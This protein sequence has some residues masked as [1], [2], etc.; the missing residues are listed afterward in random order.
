MPDAPAIAQFE[1]RLVELGCPGRRLREKVQELADHYEDLRLAALEDGLPEAEAEARATALLGNPV[2][3]AEDIVTGL[4]HSS[5]WGRHPFIGL[6]LLPPL[7]VGFFWAGCAYALYGIGYLLGWAFGPGYDMKKMAVSLMDADGE[8]FRSF[9]RPVSAGLDVASF[10]ILTAAF[11][12]VARRSAVGLRW[13]LG[14]CIACLAT[15]LAFFSTIEPHNV[16]LSMV[17]PPRHWWNIGI[18]V[19]A[20][21]FAF[22]R[23]RRMESLLTPIPAEL[24]RVRPG[25]SAKSAKTIFRRMC[26]TPTYWVMAVLVVFIAVFSIEYKLSSN[27]E[28]ARKAELKNKTWPAERATTLAR[29]SEGQHATAPNR[30]TTINLKPWL[31]ATLAATT[32]GADEAKDNNLAELPKGIHTFAG[33]P[34]DV[35]GRAQLLGRALLESGKKFPERIRNIAIGRK[36]DRIHL[37]HGASNLHTLHKEIAKLRL[38]YKN[39]AVAEIGI[40]SGEHVLDWWGPI[41]TTDAGNGCHPTA[42]ETELAWVGENPWIKEQQPEDSLRLY[43]STFANPHPDLEIASID[44]VSTLKDAAPF[45]VGLTVDQSTK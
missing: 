4:R 3:L 16:S 38:H 43:K 42:P 12:W 39:G 7:L 37:L 34:F 22:V 18:P 40:I 10:V 11:C 13:I 28:Q 9:M 21:L 30:N 26:L 6:C 19:A 24:K 45:L 5:W 14:T 33:I 25:K 29:V 8:S 15:S 20:A 32:D 1:R 17:W 23:Q 36:C 31:N 41:Y 35:E 27:R 2:L 44:Y